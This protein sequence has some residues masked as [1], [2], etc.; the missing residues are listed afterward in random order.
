MIK[1]K[2]IKDVIKFLKDEN[3]YTEKDNITIQLLQT[4]Y[5]QYLDAVKEV[6]EHG[7]TITTLDFN[8]NKKT[9]INPSFKN[10]LLLQKEL[11]KIIES[12]YLTPKSRKTKKDSVE[13][14]DDPFKKML[15]DISNI[16]K[17]KEV[18]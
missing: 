5:M 2:I 14:D 11:F 9:V 6:E 8:K 12:L 16:P 3:I 18:R 7:Q 15:E 13:K 4:T 17:G 1:P 10:Q